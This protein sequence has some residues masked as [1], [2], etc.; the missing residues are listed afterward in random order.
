MRKVLIVDLPGTGVRLKGE[1]ISLLK[2]GKTEDIPLKFLEEIRIAKGVALSS[3]LLIALAEK[4][5]HISFL[6]EREEPI[7]VL[8]SP[9]SGGTVKTRREQLLSYYDGR[10]VKLAK[11]FVKTATLFRSWVLRR[12]A[13]SRP[14]ISLKLMELAS[15]IEE[16]ASR[17]D[18]VQGGRVDDVRGEL[19]ALEGTAST[20]YFQ[21]LS[22]VIPRELFSGVRTRRPPKD[23]FNAA[24]SYANS[25]VYSEALKSII[26]SGLDPFAGF[27]HM[28]RPGRFSLALDLAE[29]FI[30]YISHWTVITL[31]TKRMLRG[32]HFSEARQDGGIYLN[33]E[34]KA[35]VTRAV[36]STLARRVEYEG[37]AWRL[38]DLILLRARRLVTFVRKESDYE[39]LVPWE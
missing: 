3:D 2:G 32:E 36:S 33:Y 12:L 27:L 15:K 20:A 13:S 7:G 17:I 16:V 14:E 31:F 34:G 38:K 24:I 39:E 10:G 11:S 28:D 18:G 35:L 9:I 21:G 1:R 22:L 26:F 4:G 5:V 25:V 37:K 30:V 6:D 29:E 8:V 23:P 19:M